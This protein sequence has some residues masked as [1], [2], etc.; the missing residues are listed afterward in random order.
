[1]PG[2]DFLAVGI[3]CG[4]TLGKADMRSE[5]CVIVNEVVKS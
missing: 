3:P 5:M 2:V 4:S 1:M